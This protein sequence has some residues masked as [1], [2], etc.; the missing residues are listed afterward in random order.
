MSLSLSKSNN[1]KS[2][3]ADYPSEA[4]LENARDT[5]KPPGILSNVSIPF[6]Y[7]G[8]SDFM[9]SIVQCNLIFNLD[10]KKDNIKIYRF[11]YVTRCHTSSHVR[12][13]NTRPSDEFRT[14]IL[15]IL[16]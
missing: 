15:L 5:L 2:R 12:Q 1:T 4:E 9:H 16:L 13:H 11:M 3:I 6:Q 10:A 14:C 8:Q 7:A